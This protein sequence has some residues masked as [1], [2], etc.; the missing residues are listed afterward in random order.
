[1]LIFFA[2]GRL[3]NQ[4]FQYVFLQTI[5]NKNELVISS[6]FEELKDIFEIDNINNI[7]KKNRYFR[8]VTY[9]ILKPLLNYFSE[10]GLISSISVD[11]EVILKKYRRETVS[12]TETKGIFRFLTFVKE[13]FF[14]SEVFFNKSVAQNLYI[15]EKHLLSANVF[16]DKIPKD[17][18][19]VFV[20]I[21][22]GDYKF[23]KIYGKSTLLPIS[24]FKNKIEWFLKNRKNCFFVFLSDDPELIEREFNYI[25]N[26]SIS[27]GNDYGT[28]F[29]IMT[30]CHSSILSPSSFGWWGS[31]LLKNRDVV[32]APK[33]WLGFNSK[34]EFQSRC[35]ANFMETVEVDC[36]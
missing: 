35:I 36:D 32:F 29:S 17:K 13:G 23:F 28:D 30:K 7:N 11:Y 3:G 34:I 2:D 9:R 25:S 15:K 4:I 20:H 26:K 19:K 12:Y 8:T 16:L 10:K 6:G 5:K 22:R 14:Q 21:R 31:Y 18:H 33:Y 24:F 1:M 27:S